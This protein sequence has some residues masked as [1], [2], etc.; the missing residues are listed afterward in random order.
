MGRALYR[1]PGYD[2]G[3]MLVYNDVGQV[4]VTCDLVC[5]NTRG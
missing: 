5:I 1:D 3:N 2:A 4:Q